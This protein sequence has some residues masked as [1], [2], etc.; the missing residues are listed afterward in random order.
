MMH[1]ATMR[2]IMHHNLTS[3]PQLVTRINPLLHAAHE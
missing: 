2:C 3:F 1:K